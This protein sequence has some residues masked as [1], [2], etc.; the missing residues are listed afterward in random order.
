M[1]NIIIVLIWFIGIPYC[2]SQNQ[3]Y[4][5]PKPINIDNYKFVVQD[6][7]NLKRLK[8]K[9]NSNLAGPGEEKSPIMHVTSIETYDFNEDK[10]PEYF[11]YYDVGSDF[12]TFSIYREIGNK[13]QLTGKFVDYFTTFASIKNG[14]P[15]IIR[16][17]Y[18]G[19]KTNPIYYVKTLIYDKNNKKY[20][21]L[22]D[23]HLKIGDYRDLGKDAYSQK[24]YKHALVYYKNVLRPIWITASKSSVD[25]NN[26]ALVY[27]KLEKYNKARKILKNNLEKGN[28]DAITYYNL[29]LTEENLNNY[30]K[31]LKYYRKSNRLEPAEI[32]KEKIKELTKNNR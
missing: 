4:L 27:I 15:Q 21:L 13:F 6:S 30:S 1:K 23:P 26:L 28:K 22:K 32:K 24:N 25:Y 9:V 7:A 16:T 18:E 11:V 19:H 3:P 12:N 17:Y 31:A 5:F 14:M 8:A 29:G 2:L 20:R 10:T